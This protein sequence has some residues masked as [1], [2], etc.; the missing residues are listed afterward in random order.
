MWLATRLGHGAGQQQALQSVSR[1][2]VFHA[3][4]VRRVG[5]VAGASMQSNAGR[6]G[7]S[8]VACLATAG[9][10]RVAGTAGA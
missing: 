4:L 9:S 1:C 5:E 3:K 10:H 6:A 7:R 2:P 8:A